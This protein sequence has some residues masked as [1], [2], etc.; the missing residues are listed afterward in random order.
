MEKI[1][2]E[3]CG[4]CGRRLKTEQ[5]VDRGYGP[6]CFRKVKKDR[7]K[8]EFLKSQMTIDEVNGANATQSI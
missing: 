5:S 3:I 1:K 2:A 7:T 6:V 8:A 4:R